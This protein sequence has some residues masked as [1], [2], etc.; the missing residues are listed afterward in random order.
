MGFQ[1]LM[2][3]FQEYG[4]QVDP[5]LTESKWKIVSCECIGN[6]VPIEIVKNSNEFLLTTP[7]QSELRL[8]KIFWTDVEGAIDGK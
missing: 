7:Y 4:D 1:N 8:I 5:T 2:D 6:S 3:Y